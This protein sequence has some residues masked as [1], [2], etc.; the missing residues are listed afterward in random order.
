MAKTRKQKEVTV[1][2]YREMLQTAQAVYV[3]HPT[4]ISA[5]DTAALKQE[6]F[7]LDSGVNMVKNTLFKIALE[8]EGYPVPASFDEGEHMV[9]FSSDQISET[10]KILA[11]FAKE[12]EKLE[13]QGGIL[14]GKEVSAESVKELAEL[15]SKEALI[16]QL[17]SVFQGPVRGFVTVI[18]GNARELV[19]VL[20]AIKEEKDN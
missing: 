8:E 3:V 2:Q 13:I 10:A 5:N 12:T 11:K 6:L 7:D 18:N 9:L 19:Q 17:L 20:N 15:P 1:N 4:G 16:G 14:K